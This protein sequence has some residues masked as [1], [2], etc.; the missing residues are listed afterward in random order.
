MQRLNDAILRL[1]A[2]EH[3]I[4]PYFRDTFD[5]LL[6]KPLAALVQFLLRLKHPSRESHLCQ[7]LLIPRE[8][9]TTAEITAQMARF[10]TREY[11]GRIAER[12]GNTKTYGVVRA[13]FEVLENLPTHLRQ[14]VFARPI[15][16]PA[17]IRFGGP[18]P[19][20][21]PDVEDAGILSIGIKLMG[22]AGEKLL[23]DEKHTQD[24]LGISS[25]TFTTPDVN[26]N[27]KLQRHIYAGTSI[28]YFINPLDS[29]YLD[30]LMQGLYARMNTSPLE[31]RYWS[32]VPY[33]CGEG[34]AIKYS[35][36]PRSPYK[37]K[38]PWNPPDDW[39][40]QS[41]MRTL[42]AEQ[43]ELEFSIQV[44]TDPRRMQIENASLEWPERLS[45]FVPVANIRIPQQAF[46]SPEQMAFARRLS[47]NPWHALPAHR[48]L[49]NQNRARRTIYFELS[50]LRQSMNGE[51]GM[52]PDG[53]PQRLE[54]FGSIQG[55]GHEQPN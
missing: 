54:T 18:G 50:R 8:A 53:S 55:R 40:R 51:G 10:T 47:F 46:D 15:R 26:E 16:F 36:R 31:V 7:E 30:M 2:L 13:E 48:P 37:T 49:G 42:S 1:L 39:L 23:D 45:P 17:W 12:A 3:R 21:P 24:F 22:V 29:H 33:L 11:Q 43:V 38:I 14:G 32:C 6:K 19:R 9:E 41:M 35:V 52:E 34:Q 28:F 27:L 44:Q 5:A 20:S 25:P 4:D